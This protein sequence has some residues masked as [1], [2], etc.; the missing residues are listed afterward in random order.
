MSAGFVV[1]DRASGTVTRT[2]VCEPG[3]EC[4]QVVDP[5]TEDYICI[6]GIMPDPDTIRVVDG[7]IVSIGEIGNG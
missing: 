7:A 2:G 1:Y 6:D 5:A 4:D 3:W